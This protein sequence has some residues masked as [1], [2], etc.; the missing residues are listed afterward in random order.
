MSD[1]N[2]YRV[3]IP[4]SKY[5]FVVESSSAEADFGEMLSDIIMKHGLSISG[6]SG[7]CDLPQVAIRLPRLPRELIGVPEV[8]NNHGSKAW[9]VTLG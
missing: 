4:N 9:L 3:T 6:A 7:Y 2:Y 5:E 8:F 1:L